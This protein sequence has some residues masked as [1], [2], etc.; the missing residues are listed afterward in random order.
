MFN[1]SFAE[2]VKVDVSKYIKKRDDADYL[3]WAA[4]KMLLHEHGADVVMFEPVPGSDG[5]TLR[6][7]DLSFADKNGVVNRCYEVV[8]KITVDNLVW[9][10]SYPVMNGNNPVKDN[11]MNQLRVHNAVRRGFV[12]GVAERIG[13]GFNL[14][15]ATEDLPDETDDLSKHNIMKCKQRMQELITDKINM[16]IPLTVIADRLNRTEEELRNMMGWYFTL[17]KMEK[18]IWEM[19]P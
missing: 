1:K 4:C 16:G 12:K 19:Q 6:K 2:M 18:D 11:S 13:L 14:W 5:S 7:S 10:V 17:A 15:L 9:N 3:P 8:V